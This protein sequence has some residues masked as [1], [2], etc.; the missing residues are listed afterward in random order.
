MPILAKVPYMTAE[1]AAYGAFAGLFYVTLNL[2][3]VKIR[4]FPA[5]VY[6]SLVASLILGRV[7]YTFSLILALYALGVT[8][9]NP[10]AVIDAAVTGIPGIIIQLVLIPILL[11]VIEKTALFKNILEK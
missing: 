4:S 1:L 10:L 7:I 5:G 9:A 3:K 11:T 8:Q 6:I 2:R